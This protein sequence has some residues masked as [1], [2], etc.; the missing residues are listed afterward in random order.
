MGTTDREGM[1]HKA[2]VTDTDN[3][4]YPYQVTCPCAWQALARTEQEADFHKRN[5]ESQSLWIQATKG[6]QRGH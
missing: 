5:H 4:R 2:V 1:E 3:P 6:W